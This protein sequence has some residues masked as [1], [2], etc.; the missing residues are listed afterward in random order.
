MQPSYNEI[1]YYQYHHPLDSVVLEAI[2]DLYGEIF[3]NTLDEERRNKLMQATNVQVWLA[4]Y[5]G[6]TIAFK[7]GYERSETVYYSWLGGVIPAFRSGGIATELMRRQHQ[8]A[9]EYGYSQVET[10]TLNQW[11]NMLIINLKNGFD[12][13]NT[14]TDER[15]QLKITLRKTL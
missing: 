8:W 4:W 2:S 11:R 14:H 9:R 6:K 12:V 10:R 1:N 15:G 13:V 5:Q 7:I 3:G